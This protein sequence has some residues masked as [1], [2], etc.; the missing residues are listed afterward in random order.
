MRS[1]L[2]FFTMV[3]L[4]LALAPLDASQ[5]PRWRGPNENG[6]VDGNPPVE[7]SESKNVKW[8]TAIP[9][10]GHATPILWNDRIYVQSAEQVSE[11]GLLTDAVYRFKLMAIDRKTGTIVWDKTLRESHPAED[12]H[13]NTTTYASTSG[14]TDGEHLYAFFG[15]LGLYCLDFEG[16]VKWDKDL[17]DMRTKNSFGEGTSPTIHGNTLVVNWDHEGDSFIVA[18]DKRTGKELWRTDRDEITS[19]ATPLVVEHK[20]VNQVIV[21]ASG[22]TR[23]Y[24]LATGKEIWE[25]A[26]LGSNV[27]PTALHK[28]GIVYVMSGHRAPAMQAIS[29]DKAKGDIAGTDAVLWSLSQN[30]PY[31]A[32]PLLSGDRLYL[33]KGRNSI[34]SCYNAKTGEPIYGPERLPAGVGHVYASL[35]GTDDHFYIP[36]LDGT[37]MVV[38]NSAEY[39]VLGANELDQGIAASPMISGGD[40]FL[41]TYTH[42]YCIA[43]EQ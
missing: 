3:S 37:T 11:G 12:S 27:I 14:L 18:M 20:G 8:K 22:K 39:E 43:E 19:W 23:S 10:L 6:L 41:R 4:F 21:P 29:L 30:T 16:N 25:C 1:R 33:M 40:L 13:H 24:D 9:G 15:S 5:W 17:G 38:K 42:L 34:L 28:D 32:S 2:T 35:A 26:G 7:W 36:G 31:V